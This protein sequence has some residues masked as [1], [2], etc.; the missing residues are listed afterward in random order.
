ME[1][2]DAL[3]RLSP[4]SPDPIPGM[5]VQIHEIFPQFSSSMLQKIREQSSLDV[6]LKSLKEMIHAGWPAHIQQVPIHLKPYWPYRDKLATKDRIVMKAHRIIIP[7]TLQREILTK[8]HAPHQGTERTKL[9]ARTSVYWRGLYKDIEE[10]TNTCSTCEELQHS[11]QKEPLITTQ[12]RVPPRAWH[13]IGADLFGLNGSEYLV[14]ADY[15][16]KYPF[17]RNIPS[18]QSNSSTVVKIMRQLFSKQGIPEVVRTDNGLHFNGQTFQEFAR[19][20]G[21]KHITSS[22]HYP[23]SNGFIESQVKSVKSALL[24]WKMTK[25]D[26]DMSL[27]CLRATPVDH[28]LPSPAELLLGCPIQDNL[29]RKIS[30]DPSSEEVVSR[31]IERQ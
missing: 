23:R 18:G 2:A 27:L 10:T 22:P 31:L 19:D 30:R 1:V 6:E 16:S 8:L 9:R 21:F 28:K 11:Q 26:P 5:N 7:A 17:V 20:L 29:P 3:S 4:E 14:V 15:Y 24:K 12:G 25:S 13:T